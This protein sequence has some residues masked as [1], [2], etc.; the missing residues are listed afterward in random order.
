MRQWI[1]VVI[2]LLASENPK[3]GPKLSMSEVK[4][5]AIGWIFMQLKGRTILGSPK[6]KLQSLTKVRYP[7]SHS[8]CSSHY[9]IIL[10]IY[11]GTQDLSYREN[12]IE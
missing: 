10:Q 5:T 8:R 2:C 7:T 1:A 9:P 4:I 6:T 11:L 3:G 12:L